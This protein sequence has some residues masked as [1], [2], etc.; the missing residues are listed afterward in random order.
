MAMAELGPNIRFE[1]MFDGTASGETLS[2][3]P[4][5]LKDGIGNS[6]ITDTLTH[7]HDHHTYGDGRDDASFKDLFSCFEPLP[8]DMIENNMHPD[9]TSL[10]DQIGSSVFYFNRLAPEEQQLLHS[11]TELSVWS[12]ANATQERKINGMVKDVSP[13]V[14]TMAEQTLTDMETWLPQEAQ[15]TAPERLSSGKTVHAPV[16][17]LAPL[18]P[19]KRTAVITSLVT[20]SAILTACSSAPLKTPDIQ[21][22]TQTPSI[23]E[24]MVYAPPAVP[25][26]EATVVA[27]AIVETPPP[28]IVGNMP[29]VPVLSGIE[30]GAGGTELQI[31]ALTSVMQT[32]INKSKYGVI[33]A[34]GNV[35]AETG[36]NG[37]TMCISAIPESIF[38]P[39]ALPD[40]PGNGEKLT[41]LRNGV[42]QYEFTQVLA[43]V[44]V[45][46]DT[47]DA[48][49]T[50]VLGYA[51]SDNQ[52]FQAGTLR[53][54]LVKTN[55]ADGS[56]QVLNTMQAGFS[57]EDTVAV[58]GDVVKVNGKTQEWETLPSVEPTVSPDVAKP[59][60]SPNLLP[61]NAAS[62]TWE[63]GAW[64]VKNADGKI[65]AT[66]DATE[67][68][69]VYKTEN[70]QIVLSG[71]TIPNALAG[72]GSYI[73]KENISIPQ[74][75][76]LALPENEQ[77]PNPI[78]PLGYIGNVEGAEG[79][80]S[81]G[82]KWHLEEFGFDYRGIILAQSA[83]DPANLTGHDIYVAGFTTS[84]PLY[85]D[86]S[87]LIT[88]PLNDNE[89]L[90]TGFDIFSGGTYGDGI[91]TSV[92]MP[93]PDGI[94]ASFSLHELIAV[95]KD[96]S[97][98]GKRMDIQIWV[99]DTGKALNSP[100]K[101]ADSFYQPGQNI[102]VD[103]IANGTSF[104]PVET[105][106]AEQNLRVPHDLH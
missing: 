67:A 6:R 102:L 23:S 19:A 28:Q 36:A 4:F 90:F 43:E 75:W 98:V 66:W 104:D 58:E 89:A 60:V 77:D 12:I 57:M 10:W 40:R 94:T 51:L 96:P 63:N 93:P 25:P 88:I 53:Q 101:V 44:P 15:N 85:P 41:A 16:E 105:G 87:Y 18:P 42:A 73:T 59:S 21:T 103:A 91:G 49:Y 39:D 17:W 71:E 61:V 54:L 82:N 99:S 3:F 86:R 26:V 9:A 50:C 72:I 69:W 29:D 27:T 65:T 70:L 92:I 74:D 95:L 81:G 76:E 80:D 83:T 20:M 7:L 35:S 1:G 13:T 8:G 24:T 55:T 34:D 68:K 84:N 64:V 78:V 52:E 30:P 38:N 11:V 22:V 5:Q 48:T 46:A 33:I 45:P 31:N 62:E 106:I 56:V 32:A 100:N 97:V 37:N 47:A 14:R 79:V 2:R